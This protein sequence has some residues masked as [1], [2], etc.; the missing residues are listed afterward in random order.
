PVLGHGAQVGDDGTLPMERVAHDE[1]G[2]VQLLEE[3]RLLD[4]AARQ[5]DVF[6]S[7]TDGY[8][9]MGP[10]WRVTFA[11]IGTGHRRRVHEEMVGRVIWDVFPDMLGTQFEGEF[12]AAMQSRAARIFEACYK[13]TDTWYEDR[14][15]PAGDGLAL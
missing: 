2:R 12:R 14:L 6:E 5:A 10:D 4:T 15:F 8:I 11:S 3:R 13:P 9:H 7:V 1:A